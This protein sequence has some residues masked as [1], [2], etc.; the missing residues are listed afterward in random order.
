[1]KQ[2]GA[3]QEEQNIDRKLISRIRQCIHQGRRIE[4]MQT[5]KMVVTGPFPLARL[6]LSI[7]QRN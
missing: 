2:C 4:I 7:C 1:M 3:K 6:S 5:V